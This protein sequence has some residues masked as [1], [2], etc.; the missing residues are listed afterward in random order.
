MALQA[1]QEGDVPNLA[2]TAGQAH[3]LF[4]G[5]SWSEPSGISESPNLH[6]FFLIT[7]TMSDMLQLNQGSVCLTEFLFR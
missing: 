1:W 2:D 7:R 4:S 3:L 6:G 5:S